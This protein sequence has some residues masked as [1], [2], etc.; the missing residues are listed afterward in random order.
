MLPPVPAGWD[1]AANGLELGI[2]FVCGMPI[3]AKPRPVGA[4]A[5]GECEM[6]E[7]VPTLVP[8]RF[9]PVLRLMLRPTPPGEDPVV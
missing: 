5:N 6:L 4:V 8:E 1:C 3:G 7:L 9:R 2:V